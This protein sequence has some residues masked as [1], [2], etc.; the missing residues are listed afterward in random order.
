MTRTHGPIPDAVQPSRAS[1]DELEPSEEKARQ[2]EATEPRNLVVLVI[3]QVFL[4]VGWIFKT[5]T[6]IMPSFLDMVG[7][8]GWLRG[9]L[10]IL[11]RFGQS[12]PPVIFSRR[13][14]GMSH[15]SRA[16][17]GATIAMGAP[18][19]LLSVAWWS[20]GGSPQPWMPI[21]FL[22]CYATCFCCVGLA[23][24]S[25][26]T[27]QGKLIQATR[28]GRLLSASALLGSVFSI[29]AALALMGGWL[30]EPGRGF[31]YIFGF[32][33]TLFVLAGLWTLAL[34]EPADE[35]VPPSDGVVR[36]LTDSWRIVRGD[37]NFR[38]LAAVAMLFA[39]ALMLFP[40]YQ[41]LGRERLG[42]S[43]SSMMIWVVTQNASVGM[44]AF[45]AGFLADRC[46]NRLALRTLIFGTSL[47]P[48]LALVLASMGREA[49]RPWFWIIFIP[50]GL[51]PVTIKFLM[52]YTLEISEP[53]E[54]PRYLS[55]MGLCLATP[56]ILSP[57]V[58]LLVDKTS[59]EVVFF[60][61]TG[62]I[63]L[64]GL[65]TFRLVEPRHHH[66]GAGQPISPTD[67]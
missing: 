41:A 8:A 67:D 43:G 22:F 2:I 32:T 63:V 12:V 19:L 50:L 30:A 21:L 33:G 26:G 66:W 38:R 11:S 51:T 25:N 47:A 20:A 59:F 60:C 48:L 16:L 24:L 1:A 44:A 23:N 34:K 54:H 7:G 18:F 64:C 31:V 56:F 35:V 49:G 52:N 40:H 4:R 28:R 3:Y 36:Y 10:P 61:G 6:V 62:M 65:L 39:T 9:C 46:G 57:L 29:V 55:A 17:R 37:A 27:V 45:L 58:G 5:E 14:R 53:T 13:L 15:K 42:L